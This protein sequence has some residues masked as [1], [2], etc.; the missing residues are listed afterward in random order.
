MDC[1]TRLS[2]FTRLRELLPAGRIYIEK[3]LENDERLNEEWPI[4]GTVGL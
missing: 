3:I 1:E 4:D 2:Y